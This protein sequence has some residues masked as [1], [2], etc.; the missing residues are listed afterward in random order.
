MT[1]ES[2]FSQLLIGIHYTN[3]KKYQNKI[4]LTDFKVVLI[5]S[6]LHQKSCFHPYEAALGGLQWIPLDDGAP[7][8]LIHVNPAVRHLSTDRDGERDEEEARVLRVPHEHR[9]VMQKPHNIP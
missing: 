4:N 2:S 8:K 9:L 7:P 1:S 6:I 5:S 3:S